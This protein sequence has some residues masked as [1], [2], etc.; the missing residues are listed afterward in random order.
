MIKEVNGTIVNIHTDI[1]KNIESIKNSSASFSRD[2]FVNMNIVKEN[3]LTLSNK[4][5]EVK[6]EILADKKE[7]HIIVED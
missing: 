6:N 5:S 2:S 4:M 3:L 7:F 1:S